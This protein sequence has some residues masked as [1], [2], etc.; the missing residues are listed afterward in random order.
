MAV[1]PEYAA[2]LRTDPKLQVWY[3]FHSG[4]LLNEVSNPR[5]KR[6]MENIV[7]GHVKSWKGLR[8]DIILPKV[9]WVTHSS[10]VLNITGQAFA[11]PTLTFNSEQERLY[12]AIAGEDTGGLTLRFPIEFAS[13]G[14]LNHTDSVDSQIVLL[15]D[16][17][18]PRITSHAERSQHEYTHAVDPLLNSRVKDQKIIN[19]MVAI[20]GSYADSDARYS[21]LTLFPPYI[22]PYLMERFRNE[23]NFPPE[24][25]VVEMVET[26]NAL[27]YNMTHTYPK[28]PNDVV[29]RRLM[30]AKSLDDL[31]V[32][33][34]EVFPGYQ[35]PDGDWQARL[36]PRQR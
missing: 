3:E 7:H 32:K 14:R 22:I 28:L 6:E 26:I 29:T 11:I 1:N 10:N 19:E 2:I 4:V 20:V 8:R 24:N 5:D 34:P 21:G 36:H 31:K 15:P 33:W 18:T 17:Y 25:E 35:K 13:R 12:S 16:P 27:V 30:A 23:G 9:T